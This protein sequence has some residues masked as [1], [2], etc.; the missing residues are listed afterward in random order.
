MSW[1]DYL[2]IAVCAL[3]LLTVALAGLVVVPVL[4][5]F[6]D[7]DHYRLSWWDNPDG[8][9]TVAQH[10]PEWIQ[11]RTFLDAYYWT[12]IRNPARGFSLALGLPTDDITGM[13]IIEPG[14]FEQSDIKM[15]ARS[16]G[17]ACPLVYHYRRFGNGW[18]YQGKYGWKLWPYVDGTRPEPGRTISFVCYPQ[19]RKG[20]A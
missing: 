14:C 6:R 13:E 4:Y 11:P 8:I 15:I 5:L 17:R 7:G 3:A 2:K 20:Q 9:Y 12:A 19:I 18:Y 16:P 1:K 10:L